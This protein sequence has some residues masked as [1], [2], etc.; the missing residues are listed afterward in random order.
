M[1]IRDRNRIEAQLELQDEQNRSIM[2]N[3]RLRMLL[4]IIITVCLLYTSQ[5][6][7]LTMLRKTFELDE[8]SYGYELRLQAA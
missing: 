4:T 3:Q 7:T 6:E 2:K 8:T 1:C 5:T